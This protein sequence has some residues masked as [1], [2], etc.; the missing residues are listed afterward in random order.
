VLAKHELVPTEAAIA[1]ARNLMEELA[2]V[3]RGEYDGWE[4]E[5]PWRRDLNSQMAD[6]IVPS[7]VAR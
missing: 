7:P 2:G 6:S 5:V 3:F 1:A 4:A